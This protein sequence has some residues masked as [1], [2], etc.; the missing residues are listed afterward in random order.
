M[1]RTLLP[2][3]TAA[4]LFACGQPAETGTDNKDGQ[5]MGNDGEMPAHTEGDGHDHG[6]EATMRRTATTTKMA[7]RMTKPR[8]IPPPVTA[9]TTATRIDE[10]AHRPAGLVLPGAVRISK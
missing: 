2:L 6:T 10:H 1:K 3:L 7:M 4:F 9:T 5:T 8:T